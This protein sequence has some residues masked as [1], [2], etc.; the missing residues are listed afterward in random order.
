MT[1]DDLLYELTLGPV[2][3]ESMVQR[4]EARGVSAEGA[5]RHLNGLVISGRVRC[6]KA[7]GKVWYALKNEP[8]WEPP[9]TQ[10]LPTGVLAKHPE[11]KLDW[12]AAC[13][14]VE[15]HAAGHIGVHLA[16][17]ALERAMP[18]FE[19]V[20]FPEPPRPRLNLNPYGESKPRPKFDLEDEI[21]FVLENTDLLA[22]TAV[23]I[24]HRITAMKGLRP[25]ELN[26]RDVLDALK[27]LRDAKKVGTLAPDDKQGTG[28][29]KMRRK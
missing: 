10:P 5:V 11:K 29:F 23:T 25:F 20:A 3:T 18:G 12:R 4:L 16:H 26:Y 7:L 15:D 14:A 27:R 1:A 17:E 8:V 24:M 2:T 13:R 22:P 28:W 6:S 21:L 9:G 19:I